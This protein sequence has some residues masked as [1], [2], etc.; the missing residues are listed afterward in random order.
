MFMP[1]VLGVYLCKEVLC[2]KNC[3]GSIHNKFNHPG[4]IFIVCS[5]FIWQENFK[6]EDKVSIVLSHKLAA[7]WDRRHQL[8][9]PPSIGDRCDGSGFLFPFQLREVLIGCFGSTWQEYPHLVVDDLL[10]LP[11]KG[12][13]KRGMP[14]A[15]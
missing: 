6:K 11:L 1:K 14:G 15:W 12:K 8:P 7:I 2:N 10:L 5:Y 9:Q 13:R 4:F 3:I